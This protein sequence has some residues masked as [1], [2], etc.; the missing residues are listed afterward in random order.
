MVGTH[1]A[2]SGQ[3]GPGQAVLVL[4][5]PADAMEAER[6]NGANLPH[7][8]LIDPGVRPPTACSAVRDWIRLPATGDDLDARLATLRG[9]SDSVRP[10][11]LLDGNGR[12]V[13]GHQWVPLSPIGERIAEPLL[14]HLEHPVPDDRLIAAGWPGGAPSPNAFRQ[15]VSKLRRSLGK[16]DLELVATPRHTHMLRRTENF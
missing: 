11:P 7:L 13:R 9:Q 15:I 6:L 1:E 3:R 5:W 16:L 12:L 10:V 8:L 2:G 4:R 14:E